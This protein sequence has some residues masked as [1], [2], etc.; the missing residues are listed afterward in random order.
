MIDTTVATGF[1]DLHV[2]VDPDA[3]TFSVRVDGQ[4][5]GTFSY[6]VMTVLA[7]GAISLFESAADSGIEFDRASVRVGGSVQ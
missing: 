5:L 6:D 2:F 1:V 4:E 3:D 7:T